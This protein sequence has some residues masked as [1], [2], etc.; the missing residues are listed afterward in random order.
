MSLYKQW[1][2]NKEEEKDGLIM[3]HG[4]GVKFLV[5]RAGG[6]NKRYLRTLRKLSKPMLRKIQTKTATPEELRELTMDTFI[7]ACLRGWEG[8]SDEEG[9]V[10]ECN[11]ENAKKLFTDLPDL[12]DALQEDAQEAALYRDT[13]LEEDAKN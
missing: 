3:D 1:N 7:A 9:K 4:D 8:V 13:E 12:F 6:A 2:T 10:M 5:A 11:P